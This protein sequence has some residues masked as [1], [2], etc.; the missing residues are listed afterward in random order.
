MTHPSTHDW[1]AARHFAAWKVHRHRVNVLSLAA[2]VAMLILAGSPAGAS[3]EPI[4]IDFENFPAGPSNFG[5]P[6]HP[7]TVAGA[8]FSG[9]ILLTNESASIDLTN[10]YA[11]VDCCGYS[12]PLNIAFDSAVVNLSV[13][14][15][16]NVNA[17]YTLADNLGRSVSLSTP[18]YNVP[19]TLTLPFEGIMAATIT[20]TGVPGF[21]FA[22]DNV[23]FTAGSAPVPEPGTMVVVGGG[24]VEMLRRRR[25]RRAPEARCFSS[26]SQ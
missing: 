15:T 21:D 9:G 25:A 22:I 23:S 12:N 13:L 18:A 10:V 4:M 1:V 5:P 19:I 6:P 26:A 14:V 2:I 11:T 17:T 3:A 8:T 20:S 24:I 16:N 7:V